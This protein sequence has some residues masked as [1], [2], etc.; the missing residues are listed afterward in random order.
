[1]AAI[2]PRWGL[3]ALGAIVML[4]TGCGGEPAPPSAS[5]PVTAP[6]TAFVEAYNA[7]QL[8]PMTALMHPDIQWL[9]IDGDSVVVMADGKADLSAQMETYMASPSATRSTLST[10][11][12]DGRFVAVQETAHWT[13]DAG[14]ATAQSSLAIYELED[15]LIRRVWYYPA[16]AKP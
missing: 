2:D 7:R 3:T 16:T 10:P 14:D 4:A 13:N 11:I 1:M 6:V 9:A 8:S 5:S 12:V 15:G